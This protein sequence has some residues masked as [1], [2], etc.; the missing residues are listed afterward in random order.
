MPLVGLPYGLPGRVFRS[1]MPF[2]T[3]DP[4]RTLFLDYQRERISAI[5]L[6][7]DD[8]ECRRIT[9]F[10]LRDFYL[11]QGKKVIYLPIPD[12]GTPRITKM[13]DAV[14]LASMYARQCYHLVVHCHAGIGRTGMF[15]ACMAVSN[16]GYSSGEAISWV[17]ERILGAIEVPE[18]I[19]VIKLYAEGRSESC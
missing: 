11:N 19:E 5:V 1:E 7:A 6:L 8:S 18:Q 10:D 13:I 14:E 17:R 2:S 16:L 15:A 9:G 3:Y 4:N 12:F